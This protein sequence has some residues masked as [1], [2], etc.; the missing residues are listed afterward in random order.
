V[1]DAAWSNDLL[2][3]KSDALFLIDFLIRKIEERGSRGTIKSFV[4]NIDAGWGH[5]KT[6]FLQ[7]LR[8]TL[9][10]RQHIVA[11]VKMLG[12]TTTPTIR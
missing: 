12:P 1:S 10:E 3:R 2:D 11:Y 7:N 4:L 5:G 9:E 8:K 6:Y